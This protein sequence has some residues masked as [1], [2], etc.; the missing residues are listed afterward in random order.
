MATQ[1]RR[2]GLDCP[3]NR[4]QIS[5]WGVML[6][7]TVVAYW[8]VWSRLPFPGQVLYG[9]V[10]TFFQGCVL[11]SG[12]SATSADPTDPTVYE[13]RLAQQGGA[14][15]LFS[16]ENYQAYC[17]LCGTYVLLASKHC[18]QC[19]RCVHEFD[20]HCRWL[21][22]CI[23]KANYTRFAVLISVLEVSEISTTAASIYV[24]TDLPPI[25]YEFFLV[26]FLL[27]FACVTSCANGYL[28]VFHIWL[29]CNHLT[30]YEFLIGRRGQK[31][32]PMDAEHK[33]V[34]ET[35]DIVSPREPMPLLK[36][37][38]ENTG[39]RGYSE[40]TKIEERRC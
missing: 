7:T 19:N 20:H 31:T 3:W 12:F 15:S 39:I 9:A 10:F 37:D 32:A 24:L 23:G 38:M 1:G 36:S 14:S 16:A 35:N 21:N 29:R 40:A 5:A 25:S 13:H 22:N 27:I 6:Y 34:T 11:I 8:Q 2:S 17:T 26:L 18:G 33:G 4:L 28:I 30:T